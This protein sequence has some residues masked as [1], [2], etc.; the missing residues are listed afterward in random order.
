[1]TWWMWIVLGLFLTLLEFLTPGTF[2][3]PFF[4]IGAIVVGLLSLAGLGLP[5][6]AEWL[7]FSAFS[8]VGVVF[9][10]RRVVDRFKT[11]RGQRAEDIDALVGKSAVVMDAIP[12][13]AVGKVELRGTP[14]SAKNLDAEPLPQGQR[15][16]VERVDGLV[17]GVRRQ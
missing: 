14:W 17:L 13:G 6:W 5:G 10:R 15:C 3:F 9:F 12:A 4:G 11:K 16:T 2:F 8:I 1:M 7:L